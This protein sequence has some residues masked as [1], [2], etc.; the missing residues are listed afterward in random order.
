MLEL[1]LGLPFISGFGDCASKEVP[2]TPQAIPRGGL[3]HTLFRAPWVVGATRAYSGLGAEVV[4]E[5]FHK[6]SR[7]SAR[8]HL[9]ISTSRK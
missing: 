5:S 9:S 7:P 2:L 8:A 3:E 1:S 4:M 6:Y